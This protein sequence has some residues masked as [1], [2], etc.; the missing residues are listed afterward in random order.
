MKRSE[1]VALMLEF[2]R[3]A[4]EYKCGTQ[5]MSNLLKRMEAAGMLPPAVLKKTTCRV[6]EKIEGSNIE[7][8]DKIEIG[9]VH[10]WEEED[11][12]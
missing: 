5:F 3:E 12:N 1:M 2:E 11:D 8:G 4:Y 10:E 6:V 7:I 9:L